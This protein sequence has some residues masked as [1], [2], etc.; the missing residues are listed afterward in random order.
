LNDAALQ[1]ENLLAD[2]AGKEAHAIGFGKQGIVE[3]GDGNV[4]EV[5]GAIFAG[6]SLGAAL[7]LESGDRP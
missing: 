7:V 6:G 3:R 5:I 1:V 4:F 2:G